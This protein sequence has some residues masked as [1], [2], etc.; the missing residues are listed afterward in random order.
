[1]GGVDWNVASTGI[2]LWLNARTQVQFTSGDPTAQRAMHIDALRYM[3]MALPNDLSQTEIEIIR[4]SL[5]PQ[6]R[7]EN[8]LR[9]DPDTKPN[10]LRQGV[11]QAVCWIIAMI[12]ILIPIVLSAIN[13]ALV[14]ERQHKILDRALNGS[15]DFTKA[16]A[17]RGL[18]LGDALVRFKGT[19]LGNTCLSTISWVVEGFAG[20][21]NDGLVQ[22]TNN[23]LRLESKKE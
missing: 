15:A 9:L 8:T 12:F 19:P 23:H 14:Y 13:R 11:A 21:I 18:D 20:G 16:M 22:S 10:A 17:E 2:K 1:M 5:H 3:N 4:A 7:S 6:I